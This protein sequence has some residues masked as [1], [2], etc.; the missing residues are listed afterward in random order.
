[1]NSEDFAHFVRRTHDVE[2][3]MTSEQAVVG[4]QAIEAAF[5]GYG[6]YVVCNLGEISLC[7]TQNVLKSA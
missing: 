7:K 4:M 1:M 5:G 3:D 6:A 2:V